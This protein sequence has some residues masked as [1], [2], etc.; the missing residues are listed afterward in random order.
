MREMRI[1]GLG[2][3]M[4]WDTNTGG[5]DASLESSREVGR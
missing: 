1:A 4:P 5:E 2:R 3:K